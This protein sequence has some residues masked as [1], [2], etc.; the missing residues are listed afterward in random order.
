[1]YFVE[2][3]TQLARV[4]SPKIVTIIVEIGIS[5]TMMINGNV[6]DRLS[7]SLPLIEQFVFYGLT[8]SKKLWSFLGS[9]LNIGY[10]S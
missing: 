5:V 2:W 10:V 3:K 1:M 6:Y 4:P 9:G 7:M 8:E